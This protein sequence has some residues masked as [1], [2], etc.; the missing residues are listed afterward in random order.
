M[1][2]EK[3]TFEEVKRE[4]MTEIREC[5]EYC[6]K[7]GLPSNGSTFELMAADIHRQ[8]QEDYPEYYFGN[9]I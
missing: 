1:L 5:E 6:V 9:V 8:Y 4:L 3:K 7:Q 2:N